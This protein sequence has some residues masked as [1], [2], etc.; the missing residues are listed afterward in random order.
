M[1]HY[2]FRKVCIQRIMDHAE[3]DKGAWKGQA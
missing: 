3:Y 2:K 1:V